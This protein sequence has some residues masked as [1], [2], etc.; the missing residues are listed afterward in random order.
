MNLVET[1]LNRVLLTR[2]QNWITKIPANEKEL[3]KEVSWILKIELAKQPE[4]KEKRLDQE[5]KE[6]EQAEKKRKRD[7]KQ[8]SDS[9]KKAEKKQKQDEKRATDAAK[10]K[11][12]ATAN[13]KTTEKPDNGKQKPAESKTVVEDNP[14][15]NP[16]VAVNPKNMV[17]PPV[18]PDV[19][20]DPKTVVNPEPVKEKTTH[21]IS[22]VSCEEYRQVEL[23]IQ[24]D[25]IDLC[26]D[27]STVAFDEEKK[28]ILGDSGRGKAYLC[29][30]KKWK[31]MMS[32][33][34]SLLQRVM[35]EL[36]IHYGVEFDK[37]VKGLPTKDKAVLRCARSCGFITK[38]QIQIGGVSEF[39][40]YALSWSC[41]FVAGSFY[42][43]MLQLE[44]W[45]G[46][47]TNCTKVQ[48]EKFKMVKSVL[49]SSGMKEEEKSSVMFMFLQVANVAQK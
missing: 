25:V 42:D 5:K 23:E 36:D 10:K 3:L 30:D 44:S 6:A 48:E 8:A 41:P 33:H 32:L 20:V 2:L 29:P 37:K 22:E 1:G 24:K 18:N 43:T 40:K 49:N 9:A 11:A 15:V 34:Y 19:A 46:A 45:L 28:P 26:N 17:N 21:C 7:E 39:K 47:F 13:K 27:Y 4:E 38:K 16:D 12:I 14:P 35:S 31:K